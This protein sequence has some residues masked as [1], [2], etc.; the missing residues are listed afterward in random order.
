MATFKDVIG[1]EQIVT[2][3]S[4][5]LKSKKISHAYIFNGADGVGKKMVARAYARALQCEAV[6][7]DSCG[8]CRA[9]HQTDSGNGPDLRWVQLE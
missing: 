3:L 7:G 6:Y 2:H 4:T 5:A 8:M 9:C 1:H